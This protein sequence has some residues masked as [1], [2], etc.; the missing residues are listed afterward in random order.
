MAV[1][2][3]STTLN[4]INNG[5]PVLQVEGNY[6][7]IER[8]TATA[9]RSAGNVPDNTVINFNTRN[10][11]NH[12]SGGHTSGGYVAPR[13]GVYMIY[14][15]LMI[16]NDRSE[17]ND[18]YDLELNGGFYQRVYGSNGNRVHREFATG[19]CVSM[20]AGDTFRVRTRNI[21]I[22]GRSNLYSRY[23]VVFLG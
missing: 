14:L 4:E 5:S 3:G 15:W 10:N 20:S 8:I 23:N 19:V 21:Q 9:G 11:N 1:N 7:G 17:I 12:P 18:Y 22:Y 6:C 16:E 13:D 2:I